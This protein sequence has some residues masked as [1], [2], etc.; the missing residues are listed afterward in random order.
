MPIAL[1]Q[2]QHSRLAH[3]R[4]QV[5]PAQLDLVIDTC[6]C[7]RRVP[8]CPPWGKPSPARD[9]LSVRVAHP[10]PPAAAT[11][12]SRASPCGAD[13]QI[14]LRVCEGNARWCASW[15]VPAVWLLRL[16]AG[17]Q[18]LLCPNSAMRILS[19][20]EVVTM[21][22]KDHDM[23]SDTSALRVNQLHQRRQWSNYHS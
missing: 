6:I 17:S 19:W 4:D 2:L 15:P 11:L 18:A 14:T 8:P 9:D 7:V 1:P 5:L 16:V 12:A 10:P 13:R 22:G 20:S 21:S 3:A 23:T